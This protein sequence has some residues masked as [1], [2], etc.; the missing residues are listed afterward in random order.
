MGLAEIQNQINAINDKADLI[1][2]F[3]QALDTLID[4]A[5]AKLL[6][7]KA[8]NISVSTYKMQLSMAK[9]VN[10]MLPINTFIE[11]I[12]M[13][14]RDEILDQDIAY[15]RKLDIESVAGSDV[16]GDALS[17]SML[18]KDIPDKDVQFVFH[19]LSIMVTAIDRYVVLSQM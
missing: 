4:K 1:K 15:F 13:P 19:Y 17:V 8:T 5:E 10:M 11:T 12:Y 3:Y 7:L 6:E 14:Y 16:K 18:V 9:S 2:V